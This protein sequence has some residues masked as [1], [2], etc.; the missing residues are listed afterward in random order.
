MLA[1]I[2]EILR[3]A[4]EYPMLQDGVLSRTTEYWLQVRKYAYGRQSTS[5][6]RASIVTAD[7]V[8]DAREWSTTTAERMLPQSDEELQKPTE[9]LVHSVIRD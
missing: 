9:Y 8:L 4:T 6:V 7:R 5:S 3:R 2:A 1:T